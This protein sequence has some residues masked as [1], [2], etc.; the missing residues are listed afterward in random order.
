MIPANPL[1]RCCIPALALMLAIP[2]TR[3]DAQVAA[4]TDM[5]ENV[6]AV[7]VRNP[8]TQPQT[9]VIELH[10]GVVRDGRLELGAVV[11]AIVGPSEF[12]LEPQAGQTV[13]LLLREEV[14]PG[15]ILRLVTTLTPIPQPRP[16]GRTTSQLILATR[17]ITK[18]IVN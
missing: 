1:A 10:H 2:S 5:R 8:S 13:R 11:D 14:E 9:V 16:E 18:L 12:H 3:L 6:A 7:E 15:T 4:V 17:L